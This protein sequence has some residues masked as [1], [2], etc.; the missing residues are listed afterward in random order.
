MCSTAILL[1]RRKFVRHVPR[2]NCCHNFSTEILAGGQRRLFRFFKPG[3]KNNFY[4]RWLLQKVGFL[5]KLWMWKLNV[6]LKWFCFSFCL[7][8]DQFLHIPWMCLRRRHKLI[9]SYMSNVGT[10][11]HIS[12]Q[13]VT[14]L[15]SFDT[16]TNLKQHN[17]LFKTKL[18]KCEN[19]QGPTING[20]SKSQEI[21]CENKWTNFKKA[22]REELFSI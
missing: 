4:K 22:L 1:F 13:L 7:V 3:V 15:I 8:Q 12:S 19:I 5:N 16:M 2:L 11:G 17:V 21:V 9:M 18:S 10:W 14:E 6:A 20:K